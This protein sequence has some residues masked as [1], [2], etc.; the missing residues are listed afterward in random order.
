MVDPAFALLDCFFRLI[1]EQDRVDGKPG[2]FSNETSSDTSSIV[3][4]T[5]PQLALWRH[6]LNTLYELSLVTVHEM[7]DVDICC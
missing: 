5:N 1:L 3:I 7:V 4:P 2:F 6:L